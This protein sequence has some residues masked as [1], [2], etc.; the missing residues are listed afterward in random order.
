MAVDYL[1]PLGFRGDPGWIGCLL[2][3]VW[4]AG[5]HPVLFAALSFLSRYCSVACCTALLRKGG[6]GVCS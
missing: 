3:E 1:A 4:R 2:V 6:A 5:Q